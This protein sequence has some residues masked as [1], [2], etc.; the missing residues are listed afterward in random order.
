[1]DR[2][3][4]DRV[5]ERRPRAQTAKLATIAP[6]LD[7]PPILPVPPPIAPPRAMVAPRRSRILDAKFTPSWVPATSP[8]SRQDRSTFRKPSNLDSRT[9]HT[10]NEPNSPPNGP[11]CVIDWCGVS[12][13][14][15]LFQT[16][17]QHKIGLERDVKSLVQKR[18]GLVM[19]AH[20]QSL[21]MFKEVRLGQYNRQALALRHEHLHSAFYEIPGHDSSHF[22]FQY[23][24]HALDDILLAGCVFREV[25]IHCVAK[26]ILGALQHLHQAGMRHSGVSI[27]SIRIVSQTGHVVLSECESCKAH[28][29]NDSLSDL[30]GLEGLGLTLLDCMEGQERGKTAAEVRAYREANKVFGLTQPERWS[31]N[32]Q[33]VDFL[34]ELFGE[35]R[36]SQQQ[37][38]RP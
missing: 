11:I 3:A 7:S 8:R 31:G 22:G 9:V 4:L 21:V 6:D 38:D 30:D 35:S 20:C 24:R 15:I 16:T 26:S 13:Q 10:F 23:A 2:R 14:L 28:D 33:L 27:R 5:F 1:M 34:G 18:Q 25:E 19:Q 37:L 17:A 29:A 12:K 36:S 32:K